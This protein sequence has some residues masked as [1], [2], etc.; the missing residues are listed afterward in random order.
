MVKSKQY[1]KL[2]AVFQKFKYGKLTFP[3]LRIGVA[4]FNYGTCAKNSTVLVSYY[5]YLFKLPV[6]TRRDIFKLE[7]L[8][9]QL[10]LADEKSRIYEV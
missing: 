5:L 8:S 7:N 9:V 6:V 10:R 3:V 4:I 2:D 1:G